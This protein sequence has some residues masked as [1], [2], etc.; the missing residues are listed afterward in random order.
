MK[1]YIIVSDGNWGTEVEA[2]YLD[3]EKAEAE[4][5]RLNKQYPLWYHSVLH[6]EVVE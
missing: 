4:A 5:E 3:R 1:V 2:V 6:R